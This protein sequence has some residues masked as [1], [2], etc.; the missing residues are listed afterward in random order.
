M[1]SPGNTLWKSRFAR[2]SPTL[3]RFSKDHSKFLPAIPMKLWRLKMNITVQIPTA[4]RRL[5]SGAGQVTCSAAN[6][7]DLFSILDQKFPDLKPHLRDEA[8]EIRRF[9]NIYVNEE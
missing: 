6:L 5:T 3:Q 7:G 2:R 1:R 9:L 8:G 4:L